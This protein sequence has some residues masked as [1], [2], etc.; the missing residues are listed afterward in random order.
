VGPSLVNIGD[1]LGKEALADSILNPSAGIAHEYVTWI[2]ETKSQGQVIGILVED[3]PQRVTVRTETGEDVRLRPSDITERRQ[4]KLS[5]MPE[6]LVNR[7][8]EEEFVDLLEFLSTL[9]EDG[10]VQSIR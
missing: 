1:K 4:S 2:L 8:T 10:R 6:D 5:M 7:M 3:T 9:K